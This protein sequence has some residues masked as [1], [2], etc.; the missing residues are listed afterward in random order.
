MLVCSRNKVKG[1]LSALKKAW[2]ICS[3]LGETTWPMEGPAHNSHLIRMSGVTLQEGCSN[4]N[5]DFRN[6]KK[7][8][9]TLSL[10]DRQ[11]QWVR[12]GSLATSIDFFPRTNYPD[13][14]DLT[15]KLWTV[16]EF[17]GSNHTSVLLASNNPQSLTTRSPLPPQLSIDHFRAP[18]P[19]GWPVSLGPFEEDQ[20]MLARETGA[21]LT[22]S[23]WNHH[24]LHFLLTHLFLVK[25]MKSEN[26]L[27][28]KADESPRANTSLISWCG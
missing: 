15:H 23:W 16:G 5:V 3:V 28:W 19:G 27:V 24:R 1:C 21:R 14:R 2:R 10:Y 22:I 4:T 11:T 12:L 18:A 7:P 6:K 9:K 8:A 25:G 26:H 20:Q 13:V 17:S